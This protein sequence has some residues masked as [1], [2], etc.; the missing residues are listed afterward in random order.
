MRPYLSRHASV[1]TALRYVRGAKAG[2][3]RPAVAIAA[4]VPLLSEGEALK[5]YDTMRE[6]DKGAAEIL[7]VTLSLPQGDH[8]SRKGWRGLID[9]LWSALGL[10]A[11]AMAWE[12]WRHDDTQTSHIHIMVALATFDGWRLDLRGRQKACDRAD[13]ALSRHLGVQHFPYPWA[14]PAQLVPPVPQRRLR[15]SEKAGLAL[16]LAG[17]ADALRATEPGNRDALV[18]A[19]EKARPAGYTLAYCHNQHGTLALQL[20]R[21]ALPRGDADAQVITGGQISPWLTP[22][23]LDRCL[24]HA[25]RLRRARW[26]LLY[27]KLLQLIPMMTPHIQTLRRIIHDKREPI[28]ARRQPVGPHAGHPWPSAAA[29]HADGGFNAASG[30]AQSVR[31]GSDTQA[32]GNDRSGHEGGGNGRNPVGAS[33]R[34]DSGDGDQ[35][36]GY[37]A[38]ASPA[39]PG[40]DEISAPPC[41]AVRERGV[42]GYAARLRLLKRAGQQEEILLDYGAAEA[43]AAAAVFACGA[44]VVISATEIAVRSETGDVPQAVMAYAKRLAEMADLP[45]SGAG[46]DAE[47]DHFEM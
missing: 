40:A 8:Q 26:F 21:P 2:V 37:G 16:F 24:V 7:T 6:T 3:Q 30:S 47:P 22:K 15:G 38:S 31:R 39:P 32:G 20:R 43:G 41:P 19:I 44:R 28:L 5:L 23:H 14:S 27:G 13:I 35:I 29:D 33:A 12:A 11:L 10:P 46:F 25:G 18:A 17:F 9:V 36:D 45:L 42:R 1:A 34:S 4:T